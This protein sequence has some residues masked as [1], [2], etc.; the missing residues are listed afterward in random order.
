MMT[1]TK[2]SPPLRLTPY[3]WAKLLH[4]RDL[5]ETEVGG[6]GISAADDLLLVEDVCSVRQQCTPVTVKFDDEAVADYF[7]RQVDQGLTPEQFGRI[8]IHTHPGNC[9]ASQRHRRRDVRAVLWDRRLGRDVHPG[10]RRPDLCP[11]AVQCRSQRRSDAAGRDRLTGSRLPP[12]DW[13]AWD[14]EYAQA[15]MPEPV[16]CEP[17]RERFD[18][19]PLPRAY[20]HA[21]LCSTPC[22]P[23][24]RWD[25]VPPASEIVH[26]D[27]VIS[28][29]DKPSQAIRRAKTSSM[30]RAIAAVKDGDAQAARLRRQYR[31]ADGDVQAR[32]ADHAGHRPAG[33]RRPAADARRQRPASC[34]ISAPTPSATPTISSSSR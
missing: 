29:D 14:A 27:D 6:F 26:C 25:D 22:G 19:G 24:A 18:W 7:D 3:A 34:S 15:V 23:N 4:L 1:T 12:A 13:A 11:A 30:G 33:A 21:K 32:A 2:G 10:P 16:I 20:S 28:G 31:R 8:W 17:R 9:P 5:G